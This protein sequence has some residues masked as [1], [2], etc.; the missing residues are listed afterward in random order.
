[1]KEKTARNAKIV[2]LR[3]KGLSL[4]AIGI[5]Y[6]I[7]RERVRQIIGGVDKLP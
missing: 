1:M 6:K 7:T 5:M 3:K 2:E 4:R